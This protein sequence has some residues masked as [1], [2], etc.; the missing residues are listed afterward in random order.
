MILSIKLWNSEKKSLYFFI[1]HITT[2]LIIIGC[3]NSIVTMDE[4][5]YLKNTNIQHY[6]LYDNFVGQTEKEFFQ[7]QD[8]LMKL[9]DFYTWLSS[10]KSFKYVIMSAQG[11]SIDGTDR[12]S[13]QVNNV[14][15]Q[16]NNIKIKEGELFSTDDY[17]IR[18]FSKTIPVL[19]GSQYSHMSI[20]DQITFYY[21]GNSFNGVVKGVLASGSS[22]KLRNE[23]KTLENHI[24]LPSLEF[25]GSPKTREEWSFQIKLYLDKTAGIVLSTIP[26]NIIQ[27][28]INNKCISL[29]MKEYGIEGHNVQKVNIWGSMGKELKKINSLFLMYII[30]ISFIGFT[31][32]CQNRIL[33]LKRKY[34]ITSLIGFKRKIIILGVGSG[35]LFDLLLPAILVIIFDYMLH[36]RLYLYKYI[37][38]YTICVHLLSF[39]TCVVLMTSERY[40]QDTRGKKYGNN[41]S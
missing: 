10:N 37:L 4:N 35:I 28:E 33:Q 1:I 34:A 41:I 8:S 20:G 9:K 32:R 26:A 3:M 6:K 7:S 39:L 36:K 23:I 11:I 38:I 14:F 17:E 5:T 2:L 19:V 13:L 27:N 31:M 30:F 21:M 18:S 24:I 25:T 16:H 12:Q 40:W 15:F 29:N 22:Y